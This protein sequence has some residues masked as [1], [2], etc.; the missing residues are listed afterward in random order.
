MAFQNEPGT[1]FSQVSLP[2]FARSSRE[3]K[4]LIRHHCAALPDGELDGELFGFD[5]G[6]EFHG[7]GPGLFELAWV[8]WFVILVGA[9]MSAYFFVRAY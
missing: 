3:A 6:D 9:G 8:R 1:R 4:A 2:V 7:Q 5:P